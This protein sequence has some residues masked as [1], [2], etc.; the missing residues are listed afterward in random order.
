MVHFPFLACDR[1]YRTNDVAREKTVEIVECGVCVLYNIMEQSHY[2]LIWPFDESRH[3][4][5]VLNQR[6]T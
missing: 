6:T 3:F 4:N 1:T 2:L 5:A